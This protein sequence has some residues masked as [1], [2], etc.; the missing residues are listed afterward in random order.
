MSR[1]KKIKKS[2][3]NYNNNLGF[4]EIDINNMKRNHLT[5]DELLYLKNKL[6]DDEI[7]LTEEDTVKLADIRDTYNSDKYG[8]VIFDSYLENKLPLT[9]FSYVVKTETGDIKTRFIFSEK[10]TPAHFKKVFKLANE[11]ELKF[12]GLLID[13]LPNGEFTIYPIGIFTII[14]RG[15]MLCYNFSQ[16]YNINNLEK[17]L[18]GHDKSQNKIE[19]LM[20]I[21]L[22]QI[23][24]IQ[25][26]LLN[27]ETNKIFKQINNKPLLEQKVD[28]A[29]DS[30]EFN[31]TKV[32]TNPKRRLNLTKRIVKGSDIIKLASMSKRTFERH[33]DYWYVIGHYRNIKA[34]KKIW[35][36][37]YW[38]G[39]KAKNYDSK[40]EN[41]ITLNP[42]QIRERVIE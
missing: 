16:I 12:R 10:A 1:I 30:K 3:K 9:D 28:Y 27:S 14:N 39:T 41:S 36:N 8:E 42:H 20:N 34:D 18:K 38:K 23:N 13:E 6:Y 37:G 25:Y 35:V 19:I 11:E 29:D 15:R 4:T 26:L 21:I 31:N 2:I 5:K 32:F 24:F 40:K 7:I 33:T 17:I 22:Q